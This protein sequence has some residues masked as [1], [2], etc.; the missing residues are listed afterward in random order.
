MDIESY[1]LINNEYKITFSDG[2]I[3]YAS[4]KQFE[5]TLYYSTHELDKAKISFI[6]QFCKVIGIYKFCKLFNLPIKEKWKL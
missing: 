2:E 4:K 5:K 3:I 1:E 6:K